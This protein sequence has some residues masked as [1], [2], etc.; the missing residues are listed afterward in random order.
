M[1]K[2]KNF[3]KPSIFIILTLA[4]MSG[5]GITE[6]AS[7]RAAEKLIEQSTGV[8]VNQEGNDVTIQSKDGDITLGGE[9]EKLP[10][11]F[12]LSAFPGAKIESSMTTDGED[13]KHYIVALSSSEPIVDLA[14]FYEEALKVKGIQPERTELQD[15]ENGSIHSIFMNGKTDL[16]NVTVQIVKDESDKENESFMLNLM[17][18]QTE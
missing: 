9:S 2:L 10:E 4:F 7:E 5:C 15:E 8:K 13:G 6:N 18:T 12:P 1:L 3:I 17:V 16:L 14:A 11:G